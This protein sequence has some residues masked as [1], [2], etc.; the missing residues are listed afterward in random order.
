MPFRPLQAFAFVAGLFFYAGPALATCPSGHTCLALQID[1]L[2][3]SPKVPGKK[4]H[5][6]PHLMDA[7]KTL[8]KVNRI[9]APCRISFISEKQWVVDPAEY[10]L[11]PLKTGTIPDLQAIITALWDPRFLEVL[12]LGK[13]LE[14]DGM[15]FAGFA[16]SSVG[17]YTEKDPGGVVIRDVHVNDGMILAHELGH[18]LNLQHTDRDDALMQP[19][20]SSGSDTELSAAECETANARIHHRF[21]SAIR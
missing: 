19:R 4:L 18:L 10:G 6:L 7:E 20:H 5:D 21:K 13:I 3:S 2:A 12:V 15:T 9:W 1:H 14:S 8:K 17:D 11:W 16:V